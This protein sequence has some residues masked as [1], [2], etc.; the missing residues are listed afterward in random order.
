MK[1]ALRDINNI[2]VPSFSLGSYKVSNQSIFY[3]LA[4]HNDKLTYY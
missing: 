4:D 3:V 1:Y 2:V